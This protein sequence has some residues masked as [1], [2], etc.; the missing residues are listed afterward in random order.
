[1]QPIAQPLGQACLKAVVPGLAGR[2]LNGQRVRGKTEEWNAV[3]HVGHRVRGLAAYRI[4][5]TG[6]LGGIVVGRPV[7]VCA[8]GSDV[9]DLQQEVPCEF[10]LGVQTVLL[11]FSGT[12]VCCNSA[13][14]CLCG[15]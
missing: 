14:R 5:R 3:S 6:K 11:N 4:L 8:S 2:F 15:G 7:Q 13:R 12:P 10:N 1:M 9:A